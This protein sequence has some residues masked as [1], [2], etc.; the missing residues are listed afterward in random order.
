MFPLG[1]Y[2]KSEVRSLARRFDLPTAEKEESMGICFV[3]EVN[4]KE[5]LKN[6]IKTKIGEVVL[7]NGTVV[8][9]HEGLA[10]YTI[11]QRHIGQFP[12]SNFSRQSTGSRIPSGQFP[13]KSK[14]QNSK[15][16]YV[17]GKN[18]KDNRLIIG[19]ENDPLLYKNQISVISVNWISGHFPKFPLKCEVRLRHRQPLQ[20]CTICHCEE[21]K[22]RGNFRLGAVVVKFDKPQR[23]VTS[24]QFAVFYLKGECLG[25]GVV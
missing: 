21:S 12:I 4:M 16:L 18:L 13:I 23:A 8:G 10:F 3:G 24:G 17:V 25:G 7:S 1:N 6:K 15:P 2:L 20:K 14:T 22:R 9:E 11:G 5:F 19:Y